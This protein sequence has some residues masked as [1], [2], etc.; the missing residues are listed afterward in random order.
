MNLVFILFA[1]QFFYCFSKEYKAVDELDLTKYDGFWYQVYGD[2][3]NKLFQG[4]G[5]CSTAQYKLIDDEVSVLNSQIDENNE[6]DEIS[7]YAYYKDEDC[8]GYLTVLLDGTPEAPY[9]VLELGPIV[10]EKYDYSIVSDNKAL[11]LYVLTRDVNRFYQSY[12]TIVLDS[13]EDFG[14]NKR[15]NEPIVMN[16]TNC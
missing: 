9:W 10:N 11:S 4:N 5:K 6:E 13:L 7:G 3:F 15:Y 1:L 8:C 2:S 12:D 16:Q 14:F